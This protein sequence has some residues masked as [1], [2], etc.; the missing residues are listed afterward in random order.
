MHPARSMPLRSGEKIAAVGHE[1]RHFA[2]S[3]AMRAVQV[4]GNGAAKAVV[5]EAISG[6]RSEEFLESGIPGG[7]EVQTNQM[8]Y[9]LTRRNPAC[10]LLPWPAQHR[11]PTIASSPI[12]QGRLLECSAPQTITQRH[13]ATAAQ[14]ALTTQ[15][16]PSC[17]GDVP[18]DNA[19]ESA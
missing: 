19:S 13:G 16:P 6:R 1:T 12:E 17:D 3:P 10:A 5:G 15:A 4:A 2:E 14:I 8:L 11:I 18:A 7:D 9:N